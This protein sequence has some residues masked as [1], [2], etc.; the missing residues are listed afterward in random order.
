MIRKLLWFDSDCR[1]SGALKF[2]VKWASINKKTFSVGICVDTTSITG[3][4]NL[5]GSAFDLY[6]IASEKAS[7]RLS[8]SDSGTHANDVD[9]AFTSLI[10][11][12]HTFADNSFI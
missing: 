2:C 9:A 8:L 1:P 3:S 10:V 11:Y 12:C 7:F 5:E 6:A 4:F